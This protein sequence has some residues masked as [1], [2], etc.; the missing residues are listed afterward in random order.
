LIDDLSVTENPDASTPLTLPFTEDFEDP[1]LPHWDAAD[2]HV[3]A[4]TIAKDGVQSV[5]MS[6]SPRIL[7][8][9]HRWLELDQPI[10]LPAGSNVQ[11][12]FW[13]RGKLWDR[14]YLRLHYSED[15]GVSWRELSDANVNHNFDLMNTWTRR[16]ASLAS[17]AGKRIRLRFEASCGRY[18][19]EAQLWLD[20]FTLAEM[21][22]G[23]TML[24]IDNVAIGSLRLNWN[25]STLPTF[26]SYRI[27][28]SLT[29]TV[30]ET[31]PVVA[32][33]TDAAT[34]TFT[35]T[36]LDSRTQYYYRIYLVDDRDTWS[37]SG[38]VSATTEGI[39]IPL[40][41]DFESG[42]DGWTLTGDWQVQDGV[43]TEG[44]AA[45]VD[46]DSNYL[47]NTDSHAVFSVNLN[48]MTWPVLTFSDQYDLAGNSY[49]RVEISTDGTT[50]SE[51][52]FVY[53][54]TGTRID[55]REN[56]IDLSPWKDQERVFIRFRL[57]TDSNI[58]DGWKIDN[59]SIAEHP[60]ES[61][62]TL[63]EGAE[64]DASAWIVSS[65]TPTENDPKDGVNC[66]VDTETQRFTPNTRHL[67]VLAK[68][69]DLTT[70]SSP[71]L[72][73]YMR[74]VLT[75]YSY[76]RVQVS[77]NGGL[78]WTDIS[79]LN[80]N[81]NYDSA[82]W[83]KKQ[84]SLDPWVGQVIRLRFKT[85]TA[86]GWS[87]SAIY[88]DNIGIG[89]ETPEAPDPVTPINSQ[90]VD[91]LRPTLT[92][93]NAFDF[94][95]DPL[96][97]RFE[98]YSDAGLTQLVAQVPAVAQGEGETSWQVDV[99]LN[100]HA[101][102][103]WRCRSDD[104][105][106]IGPWSTVAT[107]L[108]NENNN[109]PDVV[110]L[111]APSNDGV[112]W[113]YDDTLVWRTVSDPDP[114]DTIQ[115]YQIQIDDDPD[116]SSPIVNMEGITVEGVSAEAGHLVGLTINE[117]TQSNG[118]GAG[119]WYWRLR[120]R[121]SRFR[122]GEWSPTGVHFRM[123]TDYERHIYATYSPE[124]L[125]DP[126]VSGP[127]ADADGDGVGQMI[128]WACKMDPTVNSREGAPVHTV[129]KLEGVSHLAIEFNR[130]IGTDVAITLQYSSDMTTW[131]DVDSAVVE[132]LEGLDSE[133]ERCRVV[134]PSPLSGTI[135]FIRLVFKTP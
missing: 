81:S 101:T 92:V 52:G 50:W 100:D 86:R 120:A 44:S 55:W 109:A 105:D 114:G 49:G 110:E 8:G 104:G 7:D 69:L 26:T 29:S 76:F 32:I 84:V 71:L 42:I 11:V 127:D 18:N 91:V 27:H 10:D 113:S 95:S 19:P 68:E 28:R 96:N 64:V 116:F 33:I 61:R 126:Q 60:V 43:G 99:N 74:G 122:Y 37:P 40:N 132:V 34:H 1:L 75:N 17:L 5:K 85:Y 72:T 70:A 121:D 65:W 98:I 22:N 58:A 94:Q 128:E 63:F 134:D 23:V 88:L 45:L 97:Y 107:F 20:K 125:L 130:R 13:F 3:V 54:V 106:D 108:V 12:T 47:P 16:Q 83:E 46:S 73:F 57:M 111:E 66:I 123:A 119:T 62:Q 78:T 103:W 30:D 25:A 6:E 53:G 48:G 77:T 112:L 51:S 35:D 80:V 38:V 4:D 14:S 131:T 56:K 93:G 15:D 135:R 24:P 90:L 89:G 2:W 31:S 36:H 21:P 82:E 59:L 118:L 129:V 133:T 117:L 67:L 9:T 39:P 102:Y 115:D 79:S 87:D 41:Q 124:E